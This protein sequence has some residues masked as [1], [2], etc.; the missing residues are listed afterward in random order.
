MSSLHLNLFA[1]LAL[2]AT[3]ADAAEPVTPQS[4]A[5]AAGETA[6][7]ALSPAQTNAIRAIGRGVLAAKKSEADDP[8]D[9]E[10]LARLRSTLDQL[11]ATDLDP[12]N[13]GAIS[14]QGHETS[15][16]RSLREKITSRREAERSDARA[17]AAQLRSQGDLKA[18]RARTA[19]E[20]DTRSAGLPIGEQRAQLFARWSQ[21]LDT[22]LADDNLDRPGQ[23]R[24][25][26]EQ[27]R[28]T[29]GGLVEAPLT[30]GTPTL[31]AMPA[32]FALPKNNGAA[33]E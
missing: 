19:P 6:A 1:A 10:Q 5:K 20:E 33:K 12:K 8:A 31:Q 4:T 15:E 21:K 29:R 27:L 17:L 7:R 11:I 23:L 16:Q 13:R 14:V 22:A 2:L 25:L 28:P 32:G 24:A 30:H 9:A 26:R 3:A 18:A